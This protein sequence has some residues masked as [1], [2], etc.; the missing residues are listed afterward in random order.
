MISD[1]N[2]G[3]QDEGLALSKAVNLLFAAHFL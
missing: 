1:L 2:R 3:D